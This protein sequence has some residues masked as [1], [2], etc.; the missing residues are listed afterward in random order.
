MVSALGHYASVRPRALRRW[1]ASPLYLLAVVEPITAARAVPAPLSGA[2]VKE[3]IAGATIHLDTPLGIALPLTFQVDGT[4]T[5]TA[6]KL[7]FY[8]GSASDRGRWW[9]ANDTLCQKWSRWFDS[10][11]R[12]MQIRKE[13]A[14]FHWSS[15]DGKS[16]TAH[17]VA[18]APAQVV[19]PATES[20][21][22]V[23]RHV[24]AAPPAEQPIVVPKPVL[25]VQRGAP[26]VPP[27]RPVGI[28]H[29]SVAPSQQAAPVPVAKVAQLPLAPRLQ[30]YRVV[31]VRSDDALNIRA[32]PS[33]DS[34][35]V[36]AIPAGAQNLTVVGICLRAWCRV[37]YGGIE[38]W[39]NAAFLEPST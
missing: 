38:G 31:G 17:I 18:R 14:R 28:A 9:I 6:G 32:L 1:I 15:N 4:V 27:A 35:V 11:T 20:V 10:E 30:R 16:G 19:K 13:G 24:P 36:A 22:D 39:A 23:V 8:L 21:Q 5:G 12:C 33:A 2:A 37:R 3:T 34:P 29:Q 7:A 25:V 26:I